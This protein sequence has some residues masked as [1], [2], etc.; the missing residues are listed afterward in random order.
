MKEYLVPTGDGEAQF[1]ERRSRFIGHIFLTETEEEALARLKQMREQYWDA[2]HNV[3]AYIIRDGATRFSDDGEPGGTAG[4][5]VLQVLQREELYNV[6]CVVTRYFGG[7]LLGAGGLVRA[8]AHGAKIAMDA[9]GRSIKRIWTNV[10]LPCPYSWYE[11]IR[12]EVAAFGGMIRETQF[13]ADVE[14]DLLL[15]EEQAHLVDGDGYVTLEF[16][17]VEGDNIQHRFL[18]AGT[19]TGGSGR[20]YCSWWVV[21]QLCEET[22]GG[23][24]LDSLS[25]AMADNR[26]IGEFWDGYASR[27]FVAP[28]KDGTPVP[29]EGSR[30]YRTYPF[31]LAVY[32]DVLVKTV[33]QLQQ[34]Q[35]LLGLVSWLLG[36]ASFGVGAVFSILLLRHRS[37]ELKLQFILGQSRGSILVWALTEH[38]I[39]SLLGVIIGAGGFWLAFRTAPAWGPV[40]GFWVMNLAGTALAYLLTMRRKFLESNLGRE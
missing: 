12:L 32:D 8:Y 24:T 31:A 3:Y 18:A 40:A 29:W 19:Y 9:A 25:A 14:L 4:M 30:L 2:T 36:L 34:N 27:Y 17:G 5:P 7:I 21:R 28:T 33:E 37:R 13:G 23:L 15:P 26:K 11:R 35:R 16:T 39:L 38:G 20:L 10:Y 22:Y 6:T 1:I